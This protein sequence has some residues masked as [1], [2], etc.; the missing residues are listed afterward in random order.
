MT[1]KYS[2]QY[3]AYYDEDTNQW[4]ESQCDDPECEYCVNRPATPLKSI[5]ENQV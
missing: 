1:K 2:E 3:D 5:D 4:L